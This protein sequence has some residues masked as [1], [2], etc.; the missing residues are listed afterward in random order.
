MPRKM[1]IGATLIYIVHPVAVLEHE[2]FE[3][4]SKSWSP[5]I[6]HSIII[7]KHNYFQQVDVVLLLNI[8]RHELI[9]NYVLLLYQY[10][11]LVVQ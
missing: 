7:K 5:S 6:S 3:L 11:F 4:V 9:W 10:R 1:H 8:R 2:R